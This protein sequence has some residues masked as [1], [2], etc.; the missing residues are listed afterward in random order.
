M[1]PAKTCE[2]SESFGKAYLDDLFDLLG[3]SEVAAGNQPDHS[4]VTIED[5][6]ER[7]LIAG[8]NK[9]DQLRIRALET[10]RPDFYVIIGTG[11]EILVLQR[12]WITAHS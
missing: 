1:L 8:K 9:L 3:T 5:L 2:L 4:L 11:N 6:F 12:G 10:Y 7:G